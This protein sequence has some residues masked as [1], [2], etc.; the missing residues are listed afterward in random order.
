MKD[1]RYHLQ[2]YSGTATRHECPRCHDLHS[3]ARYVDERENYIA[4]NVGRCNHQDKCGYHLPPSEFFGDKGVSYTPTIDVAPKPL[5]PTDYIPEEMMIRTLRTEN[6]FLRWLTRYFSL[7]EVAQA[8]E[9]Y[10]IGDTKDDRVI[11][12]QID[13]ENRIRTGKIMMY[14][15]FTGHRVKNVSGSFDWVHRHV[16]NPYQLSQ[17]LYGLHLVDGTKP[18]AVVESAKNAIVA[19]LTIPEY[20]WV[21]TEGKQNY[22]LLEDLKGYDVTMYPDLGAYDEWKRHAVKYGFKV[23]E[24]L[25]Q[26]A[27]E[28]ERGK[29]LDIADFITKQ[30]DYERENN[31]VA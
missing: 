9:R 31:K 6:A 11:F 16:K 15:E 2:K 28:E 4:T 17:C 3:F 14:D 12:W 24:M 25:E 30:I 23:S 21:S 19:S 1:F 5:P 8:I 7:S 26:I 27:T 10:R 22:R 29:G 18:I 20:T 13:R